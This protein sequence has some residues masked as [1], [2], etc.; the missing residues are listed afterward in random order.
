MLRAPGTVAP[1]TTVSRARELFENQRVRLLLLARDGRFAGAVMRASIPDD[2][3]G[4]QP[5]GELVEAGG[6][7]VGPHDPV[8]R[9]IELL[10]V[11]RDERLPVVDDDGTIVGLV[12]FNRKRGHFCVDG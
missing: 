10:E 6:A 9:A 8:A 12:C 4:D 3:P 2:A 11:R 7:L 5:L 1:E